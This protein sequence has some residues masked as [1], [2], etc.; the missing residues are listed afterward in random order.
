VWLGQFLGKQI[1]PF[2][3]KFSKY[4][5]VGFLSASIDFFVLNFLSLATGITA[6]IHIGLINIPG[7]LLATINAYLWNKFWVFSHDEKMHVDFPKFFAVTTLGLLLNSF[8]LVLLV[9]HPF[10][11]GVSSLLW[12]NI[13]KI[14]A[15]AV[16]ILWNYAGYS[17]FVFKTIK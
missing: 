7:F 9:S 2:F 17:F 12:L 14:I 4:A 16:A 13:S 1:A 6:G 11:S 15:V 10:L 3:I 5:V 8:I